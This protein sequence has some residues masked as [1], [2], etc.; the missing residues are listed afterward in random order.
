MEGPD[1]LSSEDWNVFYGW[2]SKSFRILFLLPWSSV[3]HY[4]LTRQVCDWESR[5]SWLM[6]GNI[7][8]AL[9]KQAESGDLGMA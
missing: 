3:T 5:G 4:G 9:Q 7:I 6:S 2:F 8:A 1:A